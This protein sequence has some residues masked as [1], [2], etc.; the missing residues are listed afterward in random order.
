MNLTVSRLLLLYLLP[1]AFVQQSLCIQF[2]KIS[3]YLKLSFRA[4][5]DIMFNS[6]CTNSHA[7]F[8]ISQYIK[9]AIFT[10]IE[11]GKGLVIKTRL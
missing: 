7:T 4:Q 11:R 6:T 5:F 3:E 10:I 9:E 8:S 2:L 1:Y